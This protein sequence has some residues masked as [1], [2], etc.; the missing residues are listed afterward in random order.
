MIAI[1]REE[2][3]C[4]EPQASNSPERVI[5]IIRKENTILLLSFINS[6]LK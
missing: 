1:T 5:A 4:H 6:D 2:I 3:L